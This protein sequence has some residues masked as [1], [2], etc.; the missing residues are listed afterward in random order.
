[1]FTPTPAAYRIFLRQCL[2]RSRAGLQAEL[3]AL[4]R[5]GRQFPAH[6]LEIVLQMAGLDEKLPLE[7]RFL[8]ANERPLPGGTFRPHPEPVFRFDEAAL[9]A[10]FDASGVE[11]R[12]LEL[13]VLLEWLV[14]IWQAL[15]PPKNCPPAFLSLE[16]DREALHLQTLEWVANPARKPSQ[17]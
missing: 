2:E 5:Q 13:Q 17:T 16:N 11:T 4:L 7:I 10:S 6:R 1:M 14:E 12:E 3:G 8:D 9:A 15:G